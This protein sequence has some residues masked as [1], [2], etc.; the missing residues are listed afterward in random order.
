M[1]MISRV[2]L[3]G[4]LVEVE[5]EVDGEFR[6][7]RRHVQGYSLMTSDQKQRLWK[8]IVGLPV[9]QVI[10]TLTPKLNVVKPSLL[11]R[12]STYIWG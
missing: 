10:P 4:D 11:T 6:K 1:S 9:P 7:V 8:D 3:T 5:A 12:L 2:T